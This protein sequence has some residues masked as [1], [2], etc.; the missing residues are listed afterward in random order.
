ML[1]ARP[2]VST[3]EIASKISFRATPRGRGKTGEYPANL[4]EVELSLMSSWNQAYAGQELDLLS[5]N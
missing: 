2:C 1:D 5:N 4:V 3:L